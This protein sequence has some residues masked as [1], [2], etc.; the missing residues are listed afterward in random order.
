MLSLGVSSACY[1]AAFTQTDNF[2]GLSNG[3]KPNFGNWT[4]VTGSDGTNGW[5][6]LTGA[7]GTGN[8]GPSTATGAAPQGPY[9]YL[10]SSGSNQ[11]YG[12][13]VTLPE[14]NS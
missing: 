6:V 1:G 12:V 3:T 9:V 11:T 4:G 13:D 14:F 2:D 8:T 10:E 7:T 5:V